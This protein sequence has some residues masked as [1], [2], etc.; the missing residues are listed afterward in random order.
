MEHFILSDSN[1]WSQDLIDASFVY[2]H[3]F[4]FF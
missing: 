2:V 4:L 3:M 1:S